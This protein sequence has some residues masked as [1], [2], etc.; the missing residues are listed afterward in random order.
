MSSTIETFARQNVAQFVQ[1]LRETL[2]HVT[3]PDNLAEMMWAK[4]TDKEE[5]RT[6]FIK[7]SIHHLKKFP[8]ELPFM[9]DAI[10]YKIGEGCCSDIVFAKGLFTPCSKPTKEGEC[11]CKAHT[12][13]ASIFGTYEERLATWD[14]GRGIGKMAI[15][16]EKTYKEATY[17]E[18]CKHANITSDIVRVALRR[19]NVGLQIDTRNYEVRAKEKKV[20]GRPT[21]N[22]VENSGSESEQEETQENEEVK[23]EEVEEVKVEEVKVEEVKVEEKKPKKKPAPRT[24]RGTSLDRGSTFERGTSLDRVEKEE[25]S[26]DEEK[27]KK[28]AA[29]KPRKLKIEPKPEEKELVKEDFEGEL[30][31]IEEFEHTDGNTYYNNQGTVYNAEKKHVGNAANGIVTLF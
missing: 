7:T 2:P 25:K 17:G 21:K 27:P 18:Y 26:S 13:T 30:D 12:E 11:K 4:M 10:D 19:E 3:F 6:N 8:Y 31:D 29:P 1:I 22:L 16:G 15:I 20:R 5:E 23:V 28:K 14:E 9:P 24:P